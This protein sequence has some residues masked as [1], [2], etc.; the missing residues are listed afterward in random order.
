MA[1][2]TTTRHTAAEQLKTA[3]AT[4]LRHSFEI[5]YQTP[6]RLDWAAEAV[7]KAPAVARILG[8]ANDTA[9]K[10]AADR[11]AQ[12]LSNAG[13]VC[14]D[15]ADQ[16]GDRTCPDCERCYE[17]YVQATRAAGWAPR[18]E[19]LATTTERLAQIRARAEAATPGPWTTDGAEIYQGTKDDVP[20][21]AKWIGETCRADENDDGKTDA[22]FIAHARTDVPTLL[23]EVNRLR[24]FADATDR[25]HEE[26]R[27][28][29]AKVDIRDSAEAW[30][31]GMAVLAILDSPPAPRVETEPRP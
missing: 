25:R 7:L 18:E 20:H 16:P 12:A 22:Q 29:F 31:L 24:I 9:A 5:W 13:A 10:D 15:C 1:T 21:F 8:Y 14:G 3:I 6:C 17:W 4:A 27:A 26:I 11:L 23:A 19:T 28:M 30:D 2:D